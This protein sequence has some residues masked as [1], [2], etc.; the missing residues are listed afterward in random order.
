MKSIDSEG[1]AKMLVTVADAMTQQRKHLIELDSAIGDGDLGIT[2]EKGFQ[3]AAAFAKNNADLAPGP[4]L[5]KSGMEIVKLAPSTMGTL[6]G[7][8]FIRGGKVL[9][10]KMELTASDLTLF[11]EGFLNGVLL[12]G[13]ASPG[14][15]TIVDILIPMVEQMKAYQG[16]D[17]VEV[18]AC[19][20]KGVQQG[21]ESE[22]GMVSQHGKAAVFRE[23]T[24]DLVDPGSEAVA[25]MISACKRSVVEESL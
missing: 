18:L 15:K 21:L 1:L 2:M 19:A 20:E 4:L 14:E 10:Q 24:L 22:K 25:I 13:K 16:D 6:M 23:K 5:V 9:D 11:F 12:R 3:A 17:I 7:S 8:G